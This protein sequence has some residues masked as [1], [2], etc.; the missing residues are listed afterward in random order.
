MSQYAI[1]VNLEEFFKLYKKAFKEGDKLVLDLLLKTLKNNNSLIEAMWGNIIPA[2][3]QS[4]KSTYFD[5]LLRA[6]RHEWIK[7]LLSYDNSALYIEAS[8]KKGLN[9]LAFIDKN[10]KYFNQIERSMEVHSIV[11]DEED[12]NNS[13]FSKEVQENFQIFSQKIQIIAEEKPLLLKKFFNLQIERLVE[14]S[15]TLVKRPAFFTYIALFE[16][17]IE[18]LRKIKS[19]DWKMQDELG[20]NILFHI[21]KY[22]PQLI[23]EVLS[24]TNIEDWAIMNNKEK[25][26]VRKLAEADLTKIH[27]VKRLNYL[28]EKE[29]VPFDNNNFRIMLKRVMK[30]YNLGTNTISLNQEI[31]NAFTL[32]INHNLIESLEGKNALE[33]L[34]DPKIESEK[35]KKLNYIILNNKLQNGLVDKTVEKKKMKL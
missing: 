23:E 15:S 17:N 14:N 16:N 4:V 31:E 32:L 34:K 13:N 12:I 11:K 33:Y 2:T 1:E 27:N 20:Q 25:T 19:I 5:D 29:L 35:I 21:L 18:G 9:S 26:P 10:V 24:H 22:P 28:L 30:S 8:L 3:T 7:T 6:N